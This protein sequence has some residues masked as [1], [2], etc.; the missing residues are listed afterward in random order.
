MFKPEQW[1]VSSAKIPSIKAFAFLVS[2][3]NKLRAA[4]KKNPDWI[5]TLEAVE[6]G[7]KLVAPSFTEKEVLLI[8][9]NGYVLPNNKAISSVY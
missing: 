6:A 8:Y 4:G 3:E 9:D 7:S 1:V 2:I 5:T